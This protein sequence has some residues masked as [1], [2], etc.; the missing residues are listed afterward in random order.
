MAGVNTF[1][2]T[3]Y[4]AWDSSIDAPF[5]KFDCWLLGQL[6]IPESYIETYEAETC[7]TRYWGGNLRL[8]QHSGNRYTF[9][10]NTLRNVALTHAT[11][12]N[13]RGVPQGFGGDD[14]I[15]AGHP[16]VRSSFE[17]ARWLMRPK[18][19]RTSEGHLFGHLITNGRLSYD[20]DYMAN[21]LECAIVERPYDLDFMR[22]FSDQMLALP[23]P[24]SP[25]YARVYDMFVS[26]CQSH[27]LRIASLP[28]PTDQTTTLSFTPHSIYSNGVFQK[29]R[30]KRFGVDL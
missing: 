21:R 3:D 1:T 13:L 22:S 15:L 5:I 8:M 30:P 18:T 9:I 25:Q 16:V 7:N 28:S 20:Y 27:S 23:Q 14:S 10:F 11:Y 17:P 19:L 4:T 26:H 29:C 12:A 6:G 24:D 2:E